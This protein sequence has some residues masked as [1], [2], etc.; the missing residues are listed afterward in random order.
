MV[1]EIILNRPFCRA[2]DWHSDRGEHDLPEGGRVTLS[3]AEVEH[4]EAAGISVE[5][6]GKQKLRMLKMNPR[7][8]MNPIGGVQ[9]EAIMR[10]RILAPAPPVILSDIGPQCV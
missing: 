2:A 3:K 8:P 7:Q 4:A 9:T 1:R 5:E 6:Y 10:P